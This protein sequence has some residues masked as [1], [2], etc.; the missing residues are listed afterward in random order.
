MARY[1]KSIWPAMPT[2]I[3]GWPAYLKGYQYRYLDAAWAQYSNRFGPV[4]AFISDNVRDAKASGLAL[5]VGLNQLA[6]GSN[7]G[8]NKGLSEFVSGKYAM[9]ASELESWGRVLLNEPYV[10][11]FLSWA[12]D[13]KYTSRSDIKQAMSSLAQTARSRSSTS[14]RGSN[15][16]TSATE[17]APPVIPPAPPV[18]TDT[19]PTVPPESQPTVPAD[20]QPVVTAP[21]PPAPQPPTPQVPAP[22]PPAPQ[23]PAPQPPVAG[24]GTPAGIVLQVSGRSA[25]GIHYMKLTWSGANGATVDVYR[26]SSQKKNTENDRRYVN[27]L[28]A[29]RAATYVYKVCEKN[30]N[31]CSKSVSVS[32]K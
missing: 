19:A 2:I 15:G 6:G 20:S 8:S 28:P 7:S 31:T 9:N 18:T 4:S 29:R 17:P 22:Q 25:K 16:Q 12:Y 11:A 26:N 5:V 30:S 24:G 14:C 32:V 27:A 13:S 3:R 10:C 23:L 21:Q 1:S